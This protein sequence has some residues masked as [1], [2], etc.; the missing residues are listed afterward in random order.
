[1][2][3]YVRIFLGHTYIHTYIHKESRIMN[4]DCFGWALKHRFLSYLIEYQKTYYILRTNF[5]AL[6]TTFLL[7]SFKSLSKETCFLF[8]IQKKIDR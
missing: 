3:C 7:K 6:P 2:L 5:L 8:Y 1:M 4:Y